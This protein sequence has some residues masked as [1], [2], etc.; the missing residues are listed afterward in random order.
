MAP[1][2]ADARSQSA[3]SRACT[4]P[5]IIKHPAVDLVE[6]ITRRCFERGLDVLARLCARLDE[7]QALLFR[8]QLRFLGRHLAFALA[9]RGTSV[10][11]VRRQRLNSLCGWEIEPCAGQWAC[12]ARPV[13]SCRNVI[14]VLRRE[15]GWS[16][17]GS[18]VAR[19][20][21]LGCAD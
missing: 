15:P 20:I 19:E 5:V 6:D 16:D 11:S 2:I 8:P 21:A 12:A 3:P 18:S 17:R 10:P 1:E 9:G 14:W 13:P 7:Q 4:H